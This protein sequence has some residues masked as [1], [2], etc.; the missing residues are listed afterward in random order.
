M[1]R[2]ILSMPRKFSACMAPPFKRELPI[3]RGEFFP[4]SFFLRGEC[5]SS[6][7]QRYPQMCSSA[8][9]L[10]QDLW[11]FTSPRKSAEHEGKRKQLRPRTH[12]RRCSFRQSASY[13]RDSCLVL[14]ESYLKRRLAGVPIEKALFKKGIRKRNVKIKKCR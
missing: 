11:T 14:H 1:P 2:A 10:L 9:K 5:C 12:S 3:F 6:S 8:K 7:P 13:Q 4:L